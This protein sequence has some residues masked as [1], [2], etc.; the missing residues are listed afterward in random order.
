MELIKFKIKYIRT[1]FGKIGFEKESTALQVRLRDQ[2]LP[3]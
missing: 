3:S 2:G 1:S